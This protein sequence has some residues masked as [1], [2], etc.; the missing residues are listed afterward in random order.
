MVIRS[1][2]L[3][4]ELMLA[5]A[6]KIKALC[7]SSLFS[8]LCALWDRK[9][10]TFMILRSYIACSRCKKVT[11]LRVGL[12]AR[13]LERVIY[14]CK[15]CNSEIC[16]V[17]KADVNDLAGSGLTSIEGGERLEVGKVPPE[18]AFAITA[19]SDFPTMITPP[20]DFMDSPYLQ[21]V[22]RVGIEAFMNRA[23]RQGI[24]DA[25]AEQH[26]ADLERLTRNF[27]DENWT[28][29][30]QDAQQWI[31]GRFDVNNHYS[32][33][34]AMNV[35]FGFVT[36]PVTASKVHVQTVSAM[37]A[38]LV[39]VAQANAGAY[40]AFLEEVCRN[41]W[42]DRSFHDFFRLSPVFVR[43]SDDFRQVLIDYDPE[44]RKCSF[45]N[46]LRITRTSGFDSI[47]QLYVDA[48]EAMSRSFTILS[49]LMNI[50]SRGDANTYPPAPKQ[51]KKFMPASMLAFEK[52]ANAPKIAMI[53]TDP[54]LS[55]LT[56]GIL[57]PSLRNA[58]GH[59]SWNYDPN[60]SVIV[61]S[62]RSAASK[63]VSIAY[64]ELLIKIIKLL[65]SLYEISNFLSMMLEDAI[66]LGIV[67]E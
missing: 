61:F 28:F 30:D 13:I 25:M 58:V 31:G 67:A 66:R 48:Y 33:I 9:Q 59:F 22:Q 37:S 14:C 51:Y 7:Y 29:F 40:K 23:P 65:V 43:A 46:G 45:P 8:V 4:G 18:A 20:T 60:N 21:A 15:N 2:R 41:Q 39:K 63:T 1:K 16:I 57:Q 42:L 38:R 26:S 34:R 11:M 50:E 52:A 62:D 32:R 3:A 53:E 49:G 35:I 24:L 64:G 47:R 10:T 5:C 44:D 56:E 27:L 12:G 36:G 55:L 54:L 19:H 6:G 17:I